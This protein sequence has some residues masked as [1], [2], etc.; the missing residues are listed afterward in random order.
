MRQIKKEK[1]KKMLRNNFGLKLAIYFA[2]IMCNFA[3]FAQDQSSF[4]AVYEN[5]NPIFTE[6]TDE[7]YYKF[8]YLRDWRINHNNRFESFSDGC[9]F[10]GIDVNNKG[11]IVTTTLSD[12]S[13][14][15]FPNRKSIYPYATRI[16]KIGFV[17]NKAGGLRESVQLKEREAT[18]R[19]KKDI[20]EYC[21]VG[22][23]H[24]PDAILDNKEIK[25]IIPKGVRINLYL[26][27][28]LNNDGAPDYI[29]V[30][31]HPTMVGTYGFSKDL[32]V[33]LI[34]IYS[35][36]KQSRYDI[37]YV[38]HISRAHPCDIKIV[39]VKGLP[40]KQVMIRSY[41]PPNNN[42]GTW[43]VSID[44]VWVKEGW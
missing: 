20:Y 27:E 19:E 5:K 36:I 40:G 43:G 15:N 11:Y 14:E 35:N 30:F 24:Y 44:L 39:K 38:N 42:S 7:D 31:T 37:Q 16:F 12:S 10:C 3:S 23:V 28:D 8:T 18:E 25:S 9:A 17:N 4:H 26:K 32:Q 1:K 22:E 13:D 21:Q 34:Q 2:T 29:V 41:S 33:K 6:F